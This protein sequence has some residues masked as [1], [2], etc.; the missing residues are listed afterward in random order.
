MGRAKRE[1]RM[2]GCCCCVWLCV[3]ACNK[4][5]CVVVVCGNKMWC[6]QCSVW[7][8]CVVIR[9]GVASGAVRVRVLVVAGSETGGECGRL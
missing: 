7:W 2:A 3:V 9:C 6:G 1:T 5:W 8:L 4:V